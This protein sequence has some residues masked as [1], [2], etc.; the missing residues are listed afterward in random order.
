[1]TLMKL[2]KWYEPGGAVNAWSPLRRNVSIESWMA[3]EKS[4]APIA[5]LVHVRG[6]SQ[7]TTESKCIEFE[8]QERR[9]WVLESCPWRWKGKPGK[10]PFNTSLSRRGGRETWA[11]SA[12]GSAASVFLCFQGRFEK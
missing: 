5:S 12:A 7:D 8:M 9:R 10:R 1:M 11:V 6:A 4:V 2:R 3:K